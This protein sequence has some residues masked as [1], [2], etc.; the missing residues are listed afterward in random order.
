MASA[1][2][3]AVP[4]RTLVVGLVISG[5]VLGTD[6]LGQT[7]PPSGEIDCQKE[8]RQTT[9]LDEGGA[10]LLCRG[11]SSTAPVECFER[12]EE[13][14]ILPVPMML[15]LCQ[16]A[17]SLAPIDCFRRFQEDSML[18]KS[19]IV[20]VCAPMSNNPLWQTCPVIRPAY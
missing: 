6:V 16:C 10:F 15:A 19:Q 2:S 20:S 11:S 9:A 17:T 1:R 3:S 4:V 12:A 5:A 18:D 8:A 14:A 7:L 13:A